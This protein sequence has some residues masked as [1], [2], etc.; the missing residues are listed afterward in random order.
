MS[1]CRAGRADDPV[2]TAVRTKAKGWAQDHLGYA[3]AA[4]QQR[5]FDEALFAVS[6][7][8]DAMQGEPEAEEASRGLE[9]IAAVRELARMDP[10]GSVAATV[11]RSALERSQDTRWAELFR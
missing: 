9:A 4:T 7:V 3:L 6:R 5:R 11:R 1:L 10:Q 2:L 8:R